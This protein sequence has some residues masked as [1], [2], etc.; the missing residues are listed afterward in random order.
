[1][2]KLV[3]LYTQIR[4]FFTLFTLIIS[5]TAVGGSLRLTSIPTHK[6]IAHVS[7]YLSNHIN[8]LSKKQK[9]PI[10]AIN[11]KIYS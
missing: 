2:L 4:I 8:I 9:Y 1:M 6:S 10:Y 7:I 3:L 5:I 11:K